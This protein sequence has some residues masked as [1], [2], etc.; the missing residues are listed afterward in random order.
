[1]RRKILWIV[2]VL[3]MIGLLYYQTYF[4]DFPGELFGIVFLP[5]TLRIKSPLK[6]FLNRSFR[7]ADSGCENS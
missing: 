5:L 7:G 2:F 3:A 4:K 6:L 1:M